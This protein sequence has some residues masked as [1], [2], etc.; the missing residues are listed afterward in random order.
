MTIFV[1]WQ[2]RVTLDS[3]RN[4]CYV[5]SLNA[6]CSPINV[7]KSSYSEPPV[8]LSTYCGDQPP[9][10]SNPNLVPNNNQTFSGASLAWKHHLEGRCSWKWQKDRIL[11]SMKVGACWGKITEFMS[12]CI[13]F[14]WSPV[15]RPEVGVNLSEI[16]FP[17]P[18]LL[19]FTF[20]PT[21]G[22]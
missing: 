17:Y 10:W 19:N 1:S 7:F 14:N 11:E 21:A 8:C 9:W 16:P 22:F 20:P 6:H 18:H 3:I 15:K 2:S 13:W 4:S 5:F 12:V